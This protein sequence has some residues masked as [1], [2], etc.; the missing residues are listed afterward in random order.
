MPAPRVGDEWKIEDFAATSA[1]CGV[2]DTVERFAS[3]YPHARATDEWLGFL[4]NVP[5]VR[6]RQA[7]PTLPLNR[8]RTLQ[9]IQ[10]GVAAWGRLHF[11]HSP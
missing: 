4:A 5:Y 9:Q 8:G 10:L 6:T 7:V 2:A 11:E 1:H 3:A